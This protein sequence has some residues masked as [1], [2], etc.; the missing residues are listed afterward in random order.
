MNCYFV[1]LTLSFQA[2][3]AGAAQSDEATMEIEYRRISLSQ[4]CR[5]NWRVRVTEAGDV[6]HTRN[7]EDCAKGELWNAPYPPEPTHRLGSWERRWLWMRIPGRRLFALP[8]HITDPT[9]ATTGGTREEVEI[10]D[11]DRHHQIVVDETTSNRTVTALRE[12]LEPFIRSDSDGPPAVPGQG[13][14]QDDRAAQ[15]PA[16]IEG[17]MPPLSERVQ[18]EAVAPS[19]PLSIDAASWPIE[20]SVTNPNSTP[21]DL[22]DPPLTGFELTRADSTFNRGQRWDSVNTRS[23]GPGETASFTFDLRARLDEPVLEPGTYS[24]QLHVSSG[25]GTTDAPRITFELHP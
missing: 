20:V 24:L 14:A 16:P 11:G 18:L 23:L 9:R 13:A 19:A 7:S 15:E 21:V 4:T 2:A 8:A 6:F 1:A 10:I 12:A 22:P 25:A 5:G 3:C 17:P